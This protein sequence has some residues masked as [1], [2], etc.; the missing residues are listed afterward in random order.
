MR[1]VGLIIVFLSLPVLI[2]LLKEYPRQRKWAY[3]AV[4]I[5][6]F[7]LTVLNMD[8]SL[9]DW[10]GWSGTTKGIIFSLLDTL[11][12]AIIV[13]ERTPIRRL[14]FL[15]VFVAYF[16]GAEYEVCEIREILPA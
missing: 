14:P 13:G 10:S 6:P 7:G 12:L 16:R 1:I 5:M 4:G 8:A 9:I 3:F 11:A 2:F 15:G